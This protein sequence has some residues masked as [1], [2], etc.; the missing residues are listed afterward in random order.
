MPLSNRSAESNRI[1]MCCTQERVSYLG[2][3]LQKIPQI[4]IRQN[5]SIDLLQT[6]F[7]ASRRRGAVELHVG[8]N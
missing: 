4:A 3:I 8:G 5:N 1:E 6:E 2:K 7:K